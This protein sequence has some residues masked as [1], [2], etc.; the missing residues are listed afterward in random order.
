MT[1]ESVLDTTYEAGLRMLLLLQA[2]GSS[3]TSDYLAVLDT[4]IV[5]AET[6][7]V[8]DRDINGVHRLAA[9]EV[10]QRSALASQ[11]LKDLAL[12]GLVC[13]EPAYGGSFTLTQNGNHVVKLMSTSYAKAY[14]TMAVAVLDQFGG[15]TEQGLIAY[16]AGKSMEGA[17]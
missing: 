8:G 12:Q 7:G 11:A 6:L 4:L 3:A 15:A 2:K 13:Y 17:H 9:G 5:N 1:Y 10:G 14:A 16:V